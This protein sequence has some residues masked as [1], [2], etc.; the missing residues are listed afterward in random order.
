MARR[1]KKE[2]LMDD[3]QKARI[4]DFFT[5][6][7]LVEYLQ[8]SAEDVIAAFGDEIEEAIEDIEELMGVRGDG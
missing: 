6:A 4:A 5:A 3:E 1:N 8:I 7:E 2:N